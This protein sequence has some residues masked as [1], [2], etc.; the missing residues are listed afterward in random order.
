MP[1]S[2][3][4]IASRK[5]TSLFQL[6]GA[7]DV[8]GSLVIPASCNLIKVWACGPG[9]GGGGGYAGATGGGGG[10]GSGGQAVIGLEIPVVPG[11]TLAW[12]VGG[13]GAA[14]AAGA[15]GG[16]GSANTYL[17]RS[18]GGYYLMRCTAGA[19]GAVGAATKGGNGGTGPGDLYISGGT[20][21]TDAKG[22]SV[23]IGS[24]TAQNLIASTAIPFLLGMPGAG[25]TYSST[26]TAYT[27]GDSGALI[28]SMPYAAGGSTSGVVGGGGGGAG[29]SC[30]PKIYPYFSAAVLGNGGADGVAG[31]SATN[32]GFGGGGGGRNAAGGS[33][34]P[35][36]IYVLYL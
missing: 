6:G 33:G 31:V 30:W 17:Y 14:G 24:Y 32:Y 35:S 25:G 26:T 27:G 9:G 2:T 16:S 3:S 5:P 15:A 22:G 4:V 36:F 19:G 13:W 1:N 10:G 21:S 29:G 34:G 7:S 12:S 20:G 8:S 28:G 11:E 23:T 18:T